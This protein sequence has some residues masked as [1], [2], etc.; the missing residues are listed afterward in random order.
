MFKNMHFFDEHSMGDLI[1]YLINNI[2]EID[3]SLGWSLN[4]FLV[5]STSDIYLYLAFIITVPSVSMGVLIFVSLC[6]IIKIF[7][8]YKVKKIK[9]A[10]EIIEYEKNLIDFI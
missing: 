9:I 8:K 2:N 1:S 10:N 5:K 7:G 4:Q 6:F 3:F